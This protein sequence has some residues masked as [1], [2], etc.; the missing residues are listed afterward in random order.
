MSSG[1]SSGS[2][3]AGQCMERTTNHASGTRLR[4]RV[5]V[6][7]EGDKAWQGWY[8]SERQETC[9][10]SRTGE[11][12][13]CL[14]SRASVFLFSDAS[15]TQPV[16]QVDPNACTAP[17]YVEMSTSAGCAAAMVRIFEL[18]EALP[19]AAPIYERDAGGVCVQSFAGGTLRNASQEV[20]LSAFV[21][22]APFTDEGPARVRAEG[23][24]GVDGTRAVQGWVD[25]AGEGRSCGFRPTED[26]IRRC[27]PSHNVYPAAYA[28]ATCT[29]QVLG[30]SPSECSPAEP[31]VR[32]VIS[33]PDVCGTA[34][35]VE[36]GGTVTGA[37]SLSISGMDEICTAEPVSSTQYF[38]V[39]PLVAPGDYA[40]IAST[41]NE[42]DSG[43]LKPRYDT[44]A[45][46]GCWF[47]TWVDSELDTPCFFMPAA[48]GQL[49]C[50]PEEDYAV[51]FVDTYTDEGCTQPRA[52]AAVNGCEDAELPKFVTQLDYAACGY[53]ASV[54]AV[55][56]PVEVAALPA[57]YALAGSNCAPYTPD[58]E[59]SWITVGPVLDPAT[60]MAAE[61][62][63]E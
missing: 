22:G 15:C 18:G 34:R 29:T 13:H 9:A 56:G 39:G 5:G 42:A 60:F 40:E 8:D 35:V 26:G 54:R 62:S 45:D 14:P 11:G 48:D 33:S 17:E 1:G 37:Y 27:L 19:A 24:V 47:D 12:S 43:R 4:A 53:P 61:V 36:R 57:L 55:E 2:G 32:A 7:A 16:A 31:D 51:G 44:T 50:M 25:S 3:N 20:P 10:F 52:I 46:G 41:M 58:P 23:V 38:A 63:V 28:D 6:T 59:Q 30:F 21:A 49:R